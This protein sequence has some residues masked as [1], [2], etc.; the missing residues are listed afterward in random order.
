M[1]NKWVYAFED[2]NATMRNLLGGKGANLA[3]MSRIGLPVPPGFT[4]TTEACIA[5]Y[6]AGEQFPDGMWDQVEANL[7]ALGEKLG[8]K[9]G[10]DSNPLL[11]SVRSGAR[12]SMPG[13][14]DTILNLGLTPAGVETMGEK[15]GDLRFAWDSYRRLIQMFGKVVLGVH[16]EPF[17]EVIT[18][19]REE[20]G[21]ATDAGVSAE[22]WK[23]CAAK[24][25]KLVE[26]HTGEPFP[27]DP[28]DQLRLG[29]AA[30]F[31]SWNA[32]RAVDYRNNFGYPHDWGTAV[33]VQTMVYGNFAD[34]Q[35]GTGVAFTR[36]PSTG[37]KRF[38]GEYLLNAQGEDVV[39]GARTPKDV[40]ELEKEIP[41]ALKELL[42]VSA[43]LENHY[44]EMQ[45]I[46][47]TIEAGKLWMLQTRNGKRTAASAVKI[48]VDMVSEGLIT[49]TEAVARINGDQIDQLLHARFDD[50]VLAKTTALAKGLN[51]SPGAAVGKVYFDADTAEEKAKE[52]EDVILVRPLTE[53]DD[54]HGMLAAKGILTQEGGA[55]SHAAVVARQLGKPCVAGCGDISINL[56][57]RFFTADGTT[58]KEGDVISLNGATGQVYVGAIP[59]VVP[60]L[61]EQKD[62]LAIL[63]WADDLRRL[64]VWANA[65]D[66]E[67]AT[68]ARGYGAQGIGLCRTEHMFLGERTQLF[69]N[70]IL[71]E[72]DAAKTK[73]LSKM[74]PEQREDFHGIFKAMDGLPVIIRL[75]DPPL[76]EFL[77]S[78]EELAVDVAVGKERGEDVSEQ[79]ALL[80]KAGELAEF[81]PMLGLRGV[82]LGVMM[83]DVNV[84][85]VRAIIEAACD[86]AKEGVDVH[87]E[88]MIPLTSHVNELKAL[89]QLL[90]DEAKAVME[91]K[92]QQIDYKFGTMIEIP[93]AAL[94]AGEVAELAQFFSFGTNDLTQMTYGI[95]RDDAERHFLLDYVEKGVLPK[96]PFQTVDR[97]GVGR[98]MAM[99]VEE[100]RKTRPGLEVGICGE[101]GGDPESID[102]CHNIGLNYVSCSPYRVPVARLAAAHA[103]LREQGWDRLGDLGARAPQ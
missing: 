44:H 58:V 95:S 34:G 18:E 76:H 94:T 24:F 32:K 28:L 10:D 56:K 45:D 65:D 21:V 68:K 61:E 67:Q 77:P 38:Y 49:E 82:R 64:Q 11:V 43:T 72:D 79:E 84:M 53:P 46:E 14:M 50:E 87:P 20:E 6:D 99:C 100:G 101:H 33:N 42:E 92:K 102:F 16:G 17:E 47:Y 54:V 78:H 71:A 40:F 70:Y 73:A 48:A 60:D 62:L 85:Q 5:Y 13:M 57:E 52:G 51:A 2:G 39:S 8:R 55:T 59:V 69:Q 23:K 35:S 75:I 80:H 27:E 83:P 1:V 26:K 7:A 29:I 97:D 63:A 25:K 31:K 93:R 30:V 88:V 103:V 96:N 86:A 91:E 89:Q 3:E 90:E 41:S 15:F 19:I 36:N 12:V 37:E 9:F 74:L 22:G 66:P 81:N 4:V 98:L